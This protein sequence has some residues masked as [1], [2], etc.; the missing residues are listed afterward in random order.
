M[1]AAENMK[2]EENIKWKYK[3]RKTLGM[4]SQLT[5]NHF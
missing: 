5:S 4:A 3:G 2:I 1:Y